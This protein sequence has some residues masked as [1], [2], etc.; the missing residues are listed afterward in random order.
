MAWRVLFLVA[1]SA[2]ASTCLCSLLPL[3]LNVLDHWLFRERPWE[4]GGA[5]TGHR[6]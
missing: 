3:R 1:L 2:L 4:Q 6:R 5:L